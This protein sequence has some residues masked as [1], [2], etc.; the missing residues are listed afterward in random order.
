MNR[1]QIF[2]IGEQFFLNELDEVKNIAYFQNK[3]ETDYFIAEFAN[4]LKIKVEILD[5]EVIEIKI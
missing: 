1:E 5:A 2:A 4:G 3:T